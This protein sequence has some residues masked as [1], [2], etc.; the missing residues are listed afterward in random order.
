MKLLGKAVLV[1]VAGGISCWAQ[2]VIDPLLDPLHGYCSVGCNDNGVNSPTSQ[3]PILGFGF[4]VSPGPA[5]RSNILIEILEPNNKTGITPTITGTDITG[6]AMATLLSGMFGSGTLE[7]FL[8]ISASPTSPIGSFL[9]TGNNGYSNVNPGATSFSVYQLSLTPVGG[10]RLQ[11]PGSPNVSPLW[12]IG[13]A[14]LP[15]GSYIVA[16]LNEGTAANPNWVATANS[17]SILETH[18]APPA[19]PEPSSIIL[20]GSVTLGLVTVLK[21]KVGTHA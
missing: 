2:V 19:V 18:D 11:G 8:G 7:G 9:T 15:L 14:G 16:F 20:L 12:N 1:L 21:K 13:S 3:D 5:T 10:I 4:T 6:S 17:G